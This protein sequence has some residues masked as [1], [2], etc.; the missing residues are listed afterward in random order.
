MNLPLPY[1]CDSKSSDQV[2]VT[3]TIEAIKS[4]PAAQAAAIARMCARRTTPPNIHLPR[5]V[6]QLPHWPESKRGV[7]NG[8]LRSA[9]FGAIKKG[10]RPYLECQEI[11]AQEG[12]AIRYTG[13]RL[14]QGDLDVWETVMHISRSQALGDECRVTAYSLLKALGKTDTGKNRN[15]LNRRLSRIK[16]TGLD[17]KVGRYSYEGSLIDEVYRDE[18]SRE[19]VIFLNPKLRVLF[20]PDQFTQIEWAVRH[21]LDGKPLAQW[22]HGYYSSHAKPYPVK[23]ET[24]HKLCGSEAELRRFRQTLCNALTDVSEASKFHGLS[25]RSEFRGNLVIVERKPTSSQQRHLRCS[26]RDII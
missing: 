23:V 26:S 21:K 20:E 1:L 22:L 11:H 15:T 17:V 25:F 5:V 3:K 12:I 16:A 6:V 19:Y 2:E 7:P 24:L 10:A 8:V 9:L 18:D 13:A 14:D 4:L